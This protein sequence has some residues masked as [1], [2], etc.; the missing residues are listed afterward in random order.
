MYLKAIQYK[1]VWLAPGSTAYELYQDRK[2]KELDQHLKQLEANELAL[3][4]QVP[5]S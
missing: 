4:K 3:L 5:G 1:G 2:L